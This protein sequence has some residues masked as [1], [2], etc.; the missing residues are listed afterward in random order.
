MNAKFTVRAIQ[1]GQAQ[2]THTVNAG[3]GQNGQ[4]LVLQAA[5]NTRYQLADM[6]TFTSPAKLQLK[7]AGKDLLVALP[8]ND[9]ATPDIVIRDYFEFE[10]MSLSGMS[11]TGQPMVYDTSSGLF[12]GITPGSTPGISAQTLAPNQTAAASLAKGSAGWFDGGW[13]LAA[14]GAGGLALAA[15]GGGGGGGTASSSLTGKIALYRQDSTKNASSLP[16]E[17]DFASA[18]VTGVNSGNLA[19]IQAFLTQ[20]NLPLDGNA[21]VQMLVDSYNR[22]TQKANGTAADNTINDPASADYR[23]LMGTN[24]PSALNDASQEYKAQ[25]VALLNDRIKSLTYSD[26]AKYGSTPSLKAYA[27]AVQA[28][29][30]L[31]QSA[32]ST[33]GTAATTGNITT[34]Q[35][36]SLGVDASN[37]TTTN[38]AAYSD[39]IR[40]S[41]DDL[42]TLNT[43]DKLTALVKAYNTI[44]AEANGTAADAT[45]ANPTAADYAA[46]GADIGTAKTDSAALARLN[47]IV[48]N[49]ANTAVDTVDEIS[50]LA[51]TLDK[52]Q[53]VAALATGATLTDAQKFS[54]DEL[55]NLGL[56]G[57][58]GTDAQ[59]TALAL[60]VSESIRDKNPADVVAGDFP[61]GKLD[62]TTSKPIKW[63]QTQLERLQTLV[64]LEI[65][66]NH[67]VDTTTPAKTTLAPTATDWANVGV[68]HNPA[69]N[70]D[71]SVTK[72]TPL[73]ATEVLALNSVVDQLPSD[74]LT[75]A[76]TTE[77]QM[78][79]DAYA[80]I[81]QEANGTDPDQNS[82]LNPTSADLM[83]LGL[84]GTV[85]A[86]GPAFNLMRDIIANRSSADVDTFTELKDLATTAA[87]IIQAAGNVDVPNFTQDEL[88]KAGL[89]SVASA[90]LNA[91]GLAYL[92]S[93]LKAL[94]STASVNTVAEV[95]AQVSLA[96]IRAWAVATDNDP[97]DTGV[98]KSAFTPSTADYA[99]LASSADRLERVDRV[100]ASPLTNGVP[101]TLTQPDVNALNTVL[102]NL[103]DDSFSSLAKIKNVAASL[104]RILNE[105]NGSADD[106]NI[107]VAGQAVLS[108]YTAIGLTGLVAATGDTLQ[109]RAFNLLDSVVRNQSYD[110]SNAG[111]TSGVDTWLEL[112][113]LSATVDTFLKYAENQSGA[114]APQVADYE[115][116]GISGVSVYN[117]SGVNAQVDA[118]NAAK[119]DSFGALQNF[120]SF[121]KIIDYAV[122]STSSNTAGAPTFTDWSS[123]AGLT[124]EVSSNL[125]V[126]NKAVDYRPR[127]DVDE[128]IDLQAIVDNYNVYVTDW[129]T[130]V[131]SGNISS[132][133]DLFHS[134]ISAKQTRENAVIVTKLMDLAERS[135]GTATTNT[136]GEPSGFNGTDLQKTDLGNLGFDVAKVGNG[137]GTNDANEMKNI[138]VAIQNSDPAQ[139]NFNY[140]Q[141]IINTWAT[142]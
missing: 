58:T 73:S 65:I 28:V 106:A 25:A 99:N 18:G 110:A 54:A 75:L 64:S 103:P 97:T 61:N 68:F 123:I 42:S 79:A 139:M 141:G 127:T 22:I 81:L 4:A 23:N 91:D 114:S 108:D 2:K 142:S 116:L 124:G 85:V 19:G 84:T 104:F 112:N 3:A 126:Y 89:L 48:G 9:V 87:K 128:L 140:I 62:T 11:T 119:S 40:A 21:S 78:L 24:T 70:A 8:G 63:S 90:I 69:T 35:L 67:V 138:W 36:T 51:A 13:G 20:T 44:L 98:S 39:A 137:S 34:P 96:L 77:L 117:I 59:N 38:L 113:K 132:T 92:E 49:L 134:L 16:T 60:K 5:P 29:S 1:Q 17:S 53:T 131:D 52:I 12:A 86:A 101:S 129:N 107:T 76:L 88:S 6:L 95:K 26:I 121:Q 47:A 32:P 14:L 46:I 115:L 133:V 74:A 55:K 83:R 43:T 80:R 94:S 56:T 66:K 57:F 109:S 30:Q 71:A 31:A 102:D 27:D 105:A 125:Q 37:V 111:Q 50:K 72:W 41:A 100:S 122:D 82:T 7:R 93:Q 135:N 136:G 130:R 15:A 120:A 33:T 118:A 45:T 10:G